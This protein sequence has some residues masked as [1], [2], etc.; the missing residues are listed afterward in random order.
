MVNG[1]ACGA[2]A[3]AMGCACVAVPMNPPGAGK[4]G[5]AGTDSVAEVAEVAEVADAADAVAGAVVAKEL[6]ALPVAAGVPPNAAGAAAAIVLVAASVPEDGAGTTAAAATGV[7]PAAACAAPFDVAG[8]PGDQASGVRCVGA[9]EGV[10]DAVD[11]AVKVLPDGAIDATAGDPCACCVSC[12]GC[13]AIA[14][15]DVPVDAAAVA[16]ATVGAVA[17]DCDVAGP[18]AVIAGVRADVVA[19]MPGAAAEGCVA[20]TPEAAFATVGADVVAEA[21]GC[22]AGWAA[23]L[24]ECVWAFAGVIVAPSADDAAAGTLPLET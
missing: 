24:V 2:G 8:M 21:D 5:I 15:K 18:D 6:G 14:P 17:D 1:W 19:A 10:A 11:V 9:A 7:V 16:A 23:A 12:A 13:D 20:V 4:V 22:A 3:D